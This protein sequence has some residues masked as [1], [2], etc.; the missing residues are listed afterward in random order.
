[1]DWPVVSNNYSVPM[2]LLFLI[3]KLIR[4]VQAIRDNVW[5][6]RA[7]LFRVW[8]IDRRHHS[9]LETCEE[10]RNHRSQSRL[11]ELE[12]DSKQISRW[13]VG[14]LKLEKHSSSTHCYSVKCLLCTSAPSINPPISFTSTCTLCA[15]PGTGPFSQRQAHSRASPDIWQRSEWIQRRIRPGSCSQGACGAGGELRHEPQYSRTG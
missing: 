1:M 6:P 10:M 12:S 2:K 13:V 5:E 9:H 14:P 4:L 15:R 11:D 3:S 7:L 8:S